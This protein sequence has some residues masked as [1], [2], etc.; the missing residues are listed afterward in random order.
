MANVEIL[1][2]RAGVEPARR[3]AG[4]SVPGNKGIK[5]VRACTIMKPAAELYAF[6]RQLENLSRVIKHPVTITAEGEGRSHWSV[7]AP[8]GD[9]PVEWESVIINDEPNKLIAWRSLDG[10]EVP[11]AGTVR[12]EPAPGGMGTEVIVQ[13]EYA[14]PA[15]RLG[16][17]FA[18]L[19]GDEP[20]QQVGDA[21]R[22]F[23]ALME[24]GEIPTA[25]GQPMGEPQR[26]KHKKEKEK[27]R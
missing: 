23:K 1:H 13:L 19:T 11:N 27:N 21:L 3:N 18:K 5:V 4:I 22:R 12:F 10:A 9:N 16:A 2:E 25:E 20:K 15:G 6:W 26:S 17:L 7:S 14:P 24:T 8:F